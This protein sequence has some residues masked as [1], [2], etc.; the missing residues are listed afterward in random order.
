[1]TLDQPSSGAPA[2]SDPIDRVIAYHIRTKHHFDRYARS[3]GFLDWAN[4]PDLF[5][6]FEGAELIRLSLLN[7]QDDP[8]SPSY[9]ALY[10]PDAV[11]SQPLTVRTLSRFFELALGLS[12]WK[13][14]GE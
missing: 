11:A 4:Q 10:Q 6:R 3:L 9:D 8:Q 14:T 13:R 12:A 7:P 1:M 5:R 2:S